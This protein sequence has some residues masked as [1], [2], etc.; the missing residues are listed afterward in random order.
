MAHTI[1]YGI[2]LGTTN[3][4]IACCTNGEVEVFRNPAGF[5]ETLP[6]VVGFRKER[7][8]V[9][10][11]A[12][13]YL[14]KDPSNVFSSF[15]RKMGTS[16]SFFVPNLVDFRTPVQLS[17]MV[18]KELRNFVRSNDSLHS[19]VVT[20]PA[21]FDT[22]QSNATRQAGIEAGFTEVVLLQEPIAA[23]LAFANKGNSLGKEGK[24][25]VY[26]LGGGTFDVALVAFADGEMK[27]LDHEG[28][29][30]LGGVDF[31]SLILEEIIVPYVETLGVFADLLHT[32]K[33]ASGSRNALYVALLY[34]AEEVKISLSSSESVDV[35]FEISD[36]LNQPLDVYLTITR[37]EFNAVIEPRI[38]ETMALASAMLVR[39]NVTGSNLRE[40]ILI[41]GSTYIPLVRQL[42]AS[43]LSLTVNVSVDPTT[44]VAVGAAWFAGSRSAAAP[45]NNADAVTVDS[46]EY[47]ISLKTAYRKNSNDAEEYFTAMVSGNIHGMYYRITRSDGGF[48]SGLKELNTRISEMLT[49]LPDSVNEF[50]IRIY[51][52]N[53]LLVDVSVP[54]IVIVRGKYSIYGQPLPSD[55]CIEVDDNATNT[56]YLEVIFEKNEIL[57]LRKTITKT[58]SRTIVK[59]TD[60][61][62]VI[63]V[64]E[65][66]RYATAQT[67]LPIGVIAIK[68]TSIERDLIKGSDVDLTIEISENRD[69][70][71]S[72]WVSI[73]DTE[74]KEVFSPSVRSV[75]IERLKDETD[76]LVRVGRRN[77]EQAIE[78]EDFEGSSRIQ[79]AIDALQ[80][81]AKRL[82]NLSGDDVTDEKYKLDE[83]KRKLAATIDTVSKDTRL[84]QLQEDYFGWKSHTQSILSAH[85]SEAL[86]VRFKNLVRDEAEFLKGSEAI[87]RRKIDDMR[88]L[89]WDIRKHDPQYVAGLYLHYA[90]KDPVE[91]TDE[92]MAQQLITRGDAALERGNMAELLEVIYRLYDLLIDKDEDEAMKGTGLA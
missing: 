41:G 49:L 48:D 67:N 1:N 79:D 45:P 70:T 85:G 24:W 39:N 51:D 44:A 57:P 18:L 53:Q 59:G 16:E 71:I 92:E 66:S 34:K 84:R 86:N 25:L 46:R 83:Q 55:I 32:L 6:S 27:V 91:Y 60:D 54:P 56:T 21:S 76:Y 38:R 52:A 43:E 26:D 50:A 80:R 10:E 47:D 87:I 69:I 63:N 29:N 78:T 17:A 37:D 68:G 5:R 75:N 13:E 40:V 64:L 89:T 72:A 31:D 11:K 90:L 58:L 82:M 14:L 77:L 9:G 88:Q 3:S 28:D 12:R 8:L 7:T 30:Y 61:Q 74:Y 15:K 73:T 62:L 81:I 33:S 23:S 36:D 2:D 20:I 4:L 42:L 65:G 19:V 35:E 22:V